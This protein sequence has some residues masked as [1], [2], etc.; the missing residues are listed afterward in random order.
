MFKVCIFVKDGK[1]NNLNLMKAI[2][3]SNGIDFTYTTVFFGLHT[4]DNEWTVT[5]TNDKTRNS[6]IH[7]FHIVA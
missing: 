3:K 1:V 7:I 6:S 2:H 4:W 5:E